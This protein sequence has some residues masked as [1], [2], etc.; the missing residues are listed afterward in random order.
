MKSEN[1]KGYS[2]ALI[3]T[4][5]Y[6]NVYIF[7]KAALNE[8]PLAQFGIWWYLVVA[9]ACLL[10]ALFNNKLKQFR[11]FGKKEFRVLLTLGFLEIFTTTLFFLSIHIIADPS[12]TSFLGNLYPV[13]VML[14]GIFILNERF[15][16]VEIFG[17]FLA[18]G[19]AFVISYTGGNTLSTF[20][21]KG[22]GV[23]FLNAI[24]ATAATLVVK[25]HVRKISPEILNL[26]RSVWLLIFSIIMFFVLREPYVYSGVALKNTMIGAILEF[27]AI[28]TVYYSFHYIEASRSSIVQ[29]LKGIVV[30]IGSYLFF[31][32]FPLPHQLIG[33]IITVTGILIMALAQAGILKLKRTTVNHNK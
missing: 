18:L 33:G 7:S 2:F 21:I 29:T 31:G 10:F 12:V 24:F 16:P 22:T 32:I 5:A 25:V 15:G 11:N 3:A 23:V 28:L 4:L 1:L 14:G 13:M 19:G 6:S 27:V 9:V 20:F 17:G 26:N 8:I 30:L